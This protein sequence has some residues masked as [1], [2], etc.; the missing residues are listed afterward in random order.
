MLSVVAVPFV[1]AVVH[2]VESFV[3]AVAVSYEAGAGASFA[4][5]A[6]L[7]AN[8]SAME[9]AVVGRNAKKES[10]FAAA[11]VGVPFGI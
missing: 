9:D 1:V 5:A 3:D 6:A 10:A 4:V 11:R 7:S 8:P 2:V